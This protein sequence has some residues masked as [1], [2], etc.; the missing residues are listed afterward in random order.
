MLAKAFPD[1]SKP[2]PVVFDPPFQDQAQQQQPEAEPVQPEA[3]PVQ[4]EVEQA[5]PEA[6]PAQ[7]EA[8]PAQPK[9]EPAQPEAEPAQPKAEP[10]LAAVGQQPETAH[11]EAEPAQPE[12]VQQ[13]V[14]ES[15]PARVTQAKPERPSVALPPPPGVA[16]GIGGNNGGLNQKKCWIFHHMNKSGG[17]TV[18]FLLKKWIHDEGYTVAQ[19]DTEGEIIYI[20]SSICVLVCG[21]HGKLCMNAPIAAG[22]CGL[23]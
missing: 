11:V 1:L 13:K 17:T 16:A 20:L 7:P 8:E 4:P 6:E 12:P 15:A 2:P 14:A 19:F 5:Q 3:E 18:K 21:R 10:A 22:K 9:A 23:F